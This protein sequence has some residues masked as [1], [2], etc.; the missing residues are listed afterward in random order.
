MRYRLL[1]PAVPEKIVYVEKPMSHGIEEGR[2]MA[3][4][5]EKYNRV[6]RSATCNVHGET[7]AMPV[8]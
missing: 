2:A 4:A 6:L 3:D 7:S 5:V 1:K 8:N